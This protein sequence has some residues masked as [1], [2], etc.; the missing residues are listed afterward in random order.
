VILYDLC[1]LPEQFRYVTINIWCLKS[2]VQLAH[3]CAPRKFTIAAENLVLQALQFK[4]DG[5]LPHIPK[6]VSMSH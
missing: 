3:R 6:R 2:H 4:K 5:Y 1:L